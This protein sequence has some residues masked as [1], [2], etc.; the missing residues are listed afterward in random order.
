MQTT[1]PII[2]PLPLPVGQAAIT[3]LPGLL[4]ITGLL[5]TAN[6]TGL[7][8]A[9]VLLAGCAIAWYWNMRILPVWCLLGLGLGL[10]PVLMLLLSILSGFLIFLP[11]QN[12]NVS[13]QLMLMV[14]FVVMVLYAA[15]VLR[16]KRFS[17]RAIIFFWLILVSCLLFSARVLFSA[18]ISADTIL[19]ITSIT[20]FQSAS[21]IFPLLL[22]LPLA[23][24]HGQAMVVFAVG[25]G[26]QGF[27]SMVNTGDQIRMTLANPAAFGVYYAVMAGLF[28]IAGPAWFLLGRTAHSRMTGLLTLVGI[29]VAANLVFS[30]LVRGDFSTTAWLSIIPYLTGILFTLELAEAIYL[31]EAA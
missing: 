31:P 9:A 4:A 27:L 17:R 12:E 14:P 13:R 3:L 21:L 19:Y 7:L 8:L 6:Q 23:K 26:F 18:G 20:L 25:V 5:N 28:L 30:G 15:V 2:D 24:K 10:Y 16:R 11:I 1:R 29:A 22:V